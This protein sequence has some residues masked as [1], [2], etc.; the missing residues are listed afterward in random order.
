[1]TE[2]SSET[3]NEVKLKKPP[4]RFKESQEII[5]Q[6]EEAID[7]PL[8]TYWNSGSG[9]VCY[10]DIN[11]IYEVLQNLGKKEK[12]GLFI[13]SGGGNGQASLRIIHL[14]RQYCDE[15]YVFVPLEC[16]SAATMIAVGADQI[17]M[18]P[19]SYLT[20]VDTS[21]QHRLSPRDHQNR[22][23]SVSLDG[24]SRVV[25][26]WKKDNNQTET[27]P[28]QALF[29]HI[30]PLVI[31]EIDRAESLSIR[32]CE[33]IMSYHIKDDSLVKSIASELNSN[34]PS[35]G[36]PITLREAC[37]IGLNAQEMDL[38]VNDLC[39]ELNRIYSEMGQTAVTD[40]DE[41]N[42]HNHAIL[43]ITE[44]KD[45]QAFYQTDEDWHYIK[46]ERR[47]SSTN[48]ESAWYR[49]EQKGKRVVRSKLHFS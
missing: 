13:K 25:D 32:L 24:V 35:H 37:R 47:W 5:T 27:N 41:F 15:L 14:L 42:Y 3:N 49:Q 31:G 43:N 1:M 34:Y 11:A 21:L 46:E 8:L 26:L 2:T 28:Y 16:A 18:G 38:K 19:M 12:I 10:S 36:Y 23:V 22:G 9:T 6:I 4:V 48:D 33:E 20:A 44:A 7:M 39:L 17:L 40:F 30:H 29:E 45:L